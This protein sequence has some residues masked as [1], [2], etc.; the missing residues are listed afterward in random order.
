MMMLCNKCKSLIM[1]KDGNEGEFV[2]RKAIGSAYEGIYLCNSCLKDNVENYY[3]LEGAY[4][5]MVN[6]GEK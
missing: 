3:K 6:V 1:Y 5:V 2:L 4:P